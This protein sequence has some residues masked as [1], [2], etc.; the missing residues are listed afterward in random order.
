MGGNDQYLHCHFIVGEGPLDIS[1]IRIGDTPIG[2]F[3][4]DVEWEVREGYATDAPLTLIPDNVD[5]TQLSILL[6]GLA[7]P[8]V[9]TTSANTDRGSV[10]L[11]FPNGLCRVKDDGSLTWRAVFV[12]IEYRESPSGVWTDA[13]GKTMPSITIDSQGS[14]Y[15]GASWDLEFTGGA[16]SGAAGRVYLIGG[17][18]SKVEVTSY[19]EG[20]TSA[21]TI[22]MPVASG[23]SGAS[24]TANMIDGIGFREETRQPI[25]RNFSFDFPSSDTYD[26]RIQ[27]LSEDATSDR[28]IDL[29][30]WTAIRS[31]SN[32]PTSI[33]TGKQKRSFFL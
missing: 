26:I 5:E 24:F 2:N 20:Y 13:I 22:T 16:G 33:V 30:Y 8:S 1:D 17:V 21:P 29:V 14:G 25:R 11:S 32:K 12:N 10:D 4:P 19:G 6:D 23:G 28:D 18:V 31:I 7:T 3:L 15:S 9:Q 27:R